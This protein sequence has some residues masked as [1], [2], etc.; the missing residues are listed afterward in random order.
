MDIV[1]AN[2]YAKANESWMGLNIAYPA[3]KPSYGDV[4][5]I[6]N[7]PEGQ[8]THYL[9]GPFG[10]TTS[11]P[12]KQRPTIPTHVNRVI[13]SSE[14]PDLAC[15]RWFEDSERV[16]FLYNWGEVIKLLQETHGS[17]SKVVVYPNAD[18]QYSL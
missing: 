14:Y 8:V 16:L 15:R 7:T 10:T 12:L 11:A 9:L 6:A 18:I 1:I 17:G 5:L 4:V 3:L 2:A 13:V